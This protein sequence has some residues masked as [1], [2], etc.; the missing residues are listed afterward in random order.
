MSKILNNKN[1]ILSIF[2]LI[3]AIFIG[4]SIIVQAQIGNIVFPIKE[5]GNCK[6]EAE[7]RNFCEVKENMIPCVNFAEQNG[8]ISK[9][10]AKLAK[11]FAKIGEGPGSCKSKEECEA[12][13]D[14]TAHIDE[15]LAFAEKNNF[16]APDELEEARKVSKALK[17]GAQLPG[18]CKGKND[19][20]AYCDNPEHMDECLVFAEK[21]GFIP[22]NELEEAKKAA[23]AMKSGI[24]SPGDCRGKKQCDTY[25]SQP[26]HMEECFNFA[27]AAGFISPEEEENARK[28]MP[29]MIRGEMPGSCRGKEQCEAYCADGSHSEE[30]ANFA[31]KAGF[32]KPEEAEMFKKTGGKGPGDCKGKEQCESFCNNSVNQEICFNFAK[33]HGLIPEGGIE[34]MKQGMMQMREGFDM[35]SPEIKTCLESAVGTEIMEKI[36]IGALTPGPQIGEQVRK[37]FEQFTPK[38]LKE[39][40]RMPNQGELPGTSGNLPEGIDNR[41]M[42]PP[43]G[44]IPGGFQGPGGCSSQEECQKYCSEHPQE[45]GSQRQEQ[46]PNSGIMPSNIPTPEMMEKIMQEQIQQQMQEQMQMMPSE[47]TLPPA[48]SN[49]LKIFQLFLKSL[50]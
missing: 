34:N 40:E 5:L 20:K 14:N 33:K 48:G 31:I 17:E 13:C 24:K 49:I 32:M 4:Y 46:A 22:A 47:E 35:A 42:M 10:E 18:G 44:M 19:C 8:L 23:K 36:K 25:C 37:C 45:C 12:Y 16:I 29:L 7:C 9:E 38:H 26:E 15:C 6:S 50:F 11:E 39:M 1:L 21:A 2:I 30:C 28:I 41:Q 27:V 3:T 43:T